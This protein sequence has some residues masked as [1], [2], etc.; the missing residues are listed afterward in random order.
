V[1]V[2]DIQCDLTATYRTFDERHDR[3][4]CFIEHESIT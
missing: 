3:I 4:L 2:D 1:I